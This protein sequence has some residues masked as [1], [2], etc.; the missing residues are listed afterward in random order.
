MSLY[1]TIFNP[2]FLTITPGGGEAPTSPAP[3]N[4]CAELALPG[5]YLFESLSFNQISFMIY[6]MVGSCFRI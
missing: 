4:F 2:E 5:N 1:L 3:L 6:D